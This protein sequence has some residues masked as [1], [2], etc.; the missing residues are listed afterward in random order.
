MP[1]STKKELAEISGLSHGTLAKIEKVDN[2]APIAIREAMGKTISIDRAAQLNRA[3][4][5]IPEEQRDAEAE[6]ILIPERQTEWARICREGR[7]MKK[8]HNIIAC[9]SLDYSYITEECVAIYI[10]RTCVTVKSI[11]GTIDDQIEWLN[12]LKELFIEGV[13]LQPESQN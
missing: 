6:R 1:I 5:N 13:K 10:R 8:I 3:L 4:Q 9:A 2:E 7:I 12:K 11:L